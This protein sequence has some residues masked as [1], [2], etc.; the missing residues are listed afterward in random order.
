M[1]KIHRLDIVMVNLD[2]TLGSE[3]KKSRPCVVISP[4]IINY[5]SKVVTIAAITSHTE[6]KEVSLLFVPIQANGSTGL[7]KKSLVTL[8]QIRTIDKARITNKLGKFPIQFNENLSY[9]IKLA[10]GLEKIT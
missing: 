3:I 6:E 2:P 4:N 7:K 8:M 9:A 5:N 1:V 10:T